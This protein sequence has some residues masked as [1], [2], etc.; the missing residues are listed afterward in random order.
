MGPVF[1]SSVRRFRRFRSPGSAERN[2]GLAKKM[3]E[4]ERRQTPGYHRRI[5]RCGAR[6]FGARTLDGVPPRLS[7]RGSYFIPKAQLQARLPGTWSERALP[8]FACPS[9]GMHLPPRSSCRGAD[10]QA[11]REQAAN[12][13]AGTA[14]AP[15][16]RCASAPR[17]STERGL[18]SNGIRDYCQVKSDIQVTMTSQGFFWSLVF[19][20]AGLVPAMTETASVGRME[21]SEIRVSIDA[22]RSFP[23]FAALHPGYLLH[24][25]TSSARSKIDMWALRCQA[26]GRSSG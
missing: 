11:A 1:Q 2:R 20:M 19:V 14:L 15:T 6:P 4:A 24:S 3:K 8:A 9:P 16:T 10:T 25:I 26:F 17:P 5:L 13:P 22:A 23:D 12:P 18:Y 21:R 7:P